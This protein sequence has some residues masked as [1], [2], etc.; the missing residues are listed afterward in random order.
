MVRCVRLWRGEWKKSVDQ[1]WDFVLGPEDY[2]YR[3]LVSKSASFEAVD[4]LRR[5]PVTVSDRLTPVVVSYRLP[6]WLLVPQGNKTPPL[7]IN[8]TA[9]LSMVLNVRTW[10]DELALLVTIG[11]KGVAEYQFLCRTNFTVGATS[12]VFDESATDNFESRL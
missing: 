5:P 9:Q 1:E 6:S 11:A 4:Q 2:G 7:T 12:Y 3:V 8:D 10:L